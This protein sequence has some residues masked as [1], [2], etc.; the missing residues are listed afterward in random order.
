MEESRRR[1]IMEQID[2]LQARMRAT[3]VAD[4]GKGTDSPQPPIVH[5]HRGL[6]SNLGTW[7]WAKVEELAAEPNK[8]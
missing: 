8:K 5:A 3:G 7:L 1:E 2:D 6:L 4:A